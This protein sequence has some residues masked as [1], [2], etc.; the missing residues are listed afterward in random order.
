VE[1]AELE[2]RVRE[3]IGRSELATLVRQTQ[4]P[5]SRLGGAILGPQA[6]NPNGSVSA[7]Q[8]TLY[9]RSDGG[10][11]STLYVRETGAADNWTAK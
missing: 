7:P 10:A 6:G 8:G 11:G 3:I 5:L 9:L 4:G 2:Q 1:L